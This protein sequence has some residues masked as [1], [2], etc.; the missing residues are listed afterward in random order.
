MVSRPNPPGTGAEQRLQALG[1][2]LPAAPMPLGAY[3]EAV[4]T[5]NLLFLSG[6]L[7]IVNGVP[8]LFGRVGAELTLEQGRAAAYAA[9]LNAVALLR[10]QLGS[11]DKVTRIVR[12]GVAIA[13]APDFV[14]HPTLADAASGL[15][16]QI[17]G[18]E[19]T[20]TRLINGVVNLPLGLP[21]AL[22]LIVETAP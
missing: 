17:F 10:Q 18:P 6:M 20:S 11:L 12:L 19:K 5:G 21:V 7:P 14:E 9:T 2:V 13:A 15:L 1:I 4:Q 22:E 3:V 8:K 16:E